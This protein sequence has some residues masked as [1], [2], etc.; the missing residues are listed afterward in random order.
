MDS[1]TDLWSRLN[2][3]R[4]THPTTRATVEGIE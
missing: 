2:H 4:A 1:S 3:F